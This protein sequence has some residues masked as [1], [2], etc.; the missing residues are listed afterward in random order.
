MLTTANIV[1]DILILIFSSFGILSAIVVLFLIVRYRQQFPFKI[2]TLL[3]CN[4]YITVIL[5][6]IFIVDTHSH[7]LYGFLHTNVSF[8][9]FYCYIRIYTIGV[10]LASIYY[11]Y[12]LQA[13][14]RLFRIVF[15]KRK[16]L[17]TFR[18]MSILILIQWL[19][20]LLL[21]LPVYLSRY[22]KY[23]SSSNYYCGLSFTNI[24]SVIY[25]SLTVYFFPTSLIGSIYFYII[26]YM[27]KQSNWTIQQY[28]RQAI[29]RDL[30]V[31]KRILILIGLLCTVSFPSIIL[32]LW[33][34]FTNDLS[35]L[36]YELQSFTFCV[37]LSVLPMI[38]AMTT[39]QLRNLLD[40]QFRLD[41]R[42][43]PVFQ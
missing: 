33:Y 38:T 20:V 28:R 13:C 18:C 7:N 23:L 1:L 16:N 39:P 37:G 8:D 5:Y 24:P 12:L 27:K 34:I 4:N 17:Q 43:H 14:F 21:P 10:T 2:A 40:R 6:L 3:I 36:I 42:I 30:T 26:F 19:F 25:T 35:P 29:Q 32:Y 9:N 41:H 15:Y 22:Y 11:S 31:L